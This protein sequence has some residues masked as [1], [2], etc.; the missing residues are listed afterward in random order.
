M[1]VDRAERYEE[2]SGVQT[3]VEAIP[4][5]SCVLHYESWQ[6]V[7]NGAD[8]AQMCRWPDS[9]DYELGW[10]ARREEVK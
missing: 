1:R 5:V 2:S 6:C 9:G 8:S 4:A 10:L 3:I 7:E